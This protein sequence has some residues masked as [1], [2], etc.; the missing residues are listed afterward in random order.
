MLTFKIFSDYEHAREIF[1]VLTSNGL[2]TELEDNSEQFNPSFTST[3]FSKQ[4]RIK[5]LPSDFELATNVCRTYFRNEVAEMN[6]DY[7]LYDFSDEELRELLIKPD[8]WSLFDYFLAEHILKNR[9]TEVETAAI[10]EEKNAHLQKLAEPEKRPVLLLIFGYLFSFGSGFI[11]LLIG[12]ILFNSKKTLYTGEEVY[13]YQHRDRVH[14]YAM[15]GISIVSMTIFV[16]RFLQL[17]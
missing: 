8:E 16:L 10:Q 5:L 17:I 15:F 2:K 12:W 6:E 7:Y 9:G 4:Y 14:G 3:L 11:G 1:G 13:T